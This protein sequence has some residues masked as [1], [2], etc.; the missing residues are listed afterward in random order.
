MR[1]IESTCHVQDHDEDHENHSI[2]SV[3][4]MAPHTREDVVKLY[5][6]GTNFYPFDGI[7]KLPER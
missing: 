1:W 2:H 3:Y 7:Y 5:M 4:F 6:H